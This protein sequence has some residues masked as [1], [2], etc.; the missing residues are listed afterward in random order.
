MTLRDNV[1]ICEIHKALNV[2]PLLFRGNSCWLHPQEIGPGVDQGPGGVITYRTWHGPVLV[3]RQQTYQLL[4]SARYF[5]A[6]WVFCLSDRPHRK[7]VF[8]NE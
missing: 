2:E 5:E 3:W 1:R 7:R 8:E 6:A 4:K